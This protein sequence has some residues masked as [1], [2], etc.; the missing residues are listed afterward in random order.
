MTAFD[1]K[2]NKAVYSRGEEL[3]DKRIRNEFPKPSFEQYY[4]LEEQL[5]KDAYEYE[6]STD[7]GKLT[8][9]E[10]YY[11][12]VEYHSIDIANE[13]LTYYEEEAVA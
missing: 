3:L 10:I 13:E 6:G 5:A 1:I 12:L 2:V 4:S 8:H 9:E 11:L 7:I